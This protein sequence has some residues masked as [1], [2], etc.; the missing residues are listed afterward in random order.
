M[1]KDLIIADPAEFSEMEGL[2]PLPHLSAQE[3]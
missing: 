1:S 2:P 3:V